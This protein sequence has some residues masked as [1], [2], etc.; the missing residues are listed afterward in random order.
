[1]KDFLLSPLLRIVLNHRLKRF[2]HMTSLHIDTTHKT[3]SITADLAGESAPIEAKMS[4]SIENRDGRLFLVPSAFECSREW[5]SL[6]AGEYLQD[7]SFAV[8]IPPG[9]PATAIKVLKL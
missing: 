9:L 1:M 3:L 2:G 6:L 4:Y 7:G 5:L 8:E